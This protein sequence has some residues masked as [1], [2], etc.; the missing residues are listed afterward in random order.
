[1]KTIICAT[2]F[3]ANSMNAVKYAAALAAELSA[4]L[5]LFH[6][7]EIPVLST[8]Q[9]FASVSFEEDQLKLSVGKKLQSVKAKLQTQY[10]SLEIIT[11]KGIGYRFV[12]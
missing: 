9:S 8:E 11:I 12:I 3:S 1:M 7:F 2:D 10:P 6:A 4:K 5:I